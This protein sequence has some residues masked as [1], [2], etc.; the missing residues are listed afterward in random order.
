MSQQEEFSLF[1][2]K[3]CHVMFKFT[4][5]P[6][7]NVK[8]F[9]STKMWEMIVTVVSSN[10][11]LCEFQ[12]K[13]SG[14]HYLLLLDGCTCSFCYHDVQCSKAELYLSCNLSLELPC[15]FFVLCFFQVVLS[16]QYQNKSQCFCQGHWEALP[17]VCFSFQNPVLFSNKLHMLIKENQ[18]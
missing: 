13:D 16:S 17:F 18:N 14:I 11:F 2:P 5:G 7:I 12:I 15:V 10:V 4:C 6:L 1:L 8:C 9:Y 3:Q